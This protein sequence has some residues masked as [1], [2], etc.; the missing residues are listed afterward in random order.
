[1]RSRLIWPVLACLVALPGVWLLAASGIT[2]SLLYYAGPAGFF[3]L[4]VV[5]AFLYALSRLAKS[6]M[7]FAED[8]GDDDDDGNPPSRDQ[9]EPL[10][11]GESHGPLLQRS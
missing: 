6:H 2:L 1:M 3:G 9:L 4:L 8:S 7:D 5:P 10:V 11:Q